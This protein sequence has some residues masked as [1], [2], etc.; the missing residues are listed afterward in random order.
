M[1]LFYPSTMYDKYID[2]QWIKKNYNTNGL[3]ISIDDNRRVL[4][5]IER[6]QQI[7]KINGK[8]IEIKTDRKYYSPTDIKG[9]LTKIGFKDIQLSLNYDLYGFKRNLDNKQLKRN[10]I[11]KAKKI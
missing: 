11:V 7:F 1:D 4:D 5:N 2:N 6:R 8:E 9:L 10:F 3:Q